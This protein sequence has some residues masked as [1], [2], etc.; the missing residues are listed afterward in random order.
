MEASRNFANKLWNAARF[1][2][3]NLGEEDF[4]PYIPQELTLEDKWVLSKYN[5]L[6]KEVTEN[7]DKFELGVAVS[8]LYDFIWDVLCDW[9]IELCKIRLSSEDPALKKNACAVLTYVMG[10]TLKLLHPFMPFITEEIWQSLP[11]EGDSIMV[12]AWP[13]YDAALDF[14]QECENMELIMAAVKAVRNR[15][16]EMNVPPSKKAQLNI[17]T[18]FTELFGGAEKYF[19]CLASASGVAASETADFDTEQSVCVITQGARIYIPMTQLIDF[20]AERKRLSKELED[21][22]KKLAQIRGKLSN[23]GFLAK[24]PEKVIA[25]QRESEA[26]FAAREQMLLESIAKLV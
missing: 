17:E 10:N 7:L 5:T 24:A 12:S 1:I 11:H 16:A 13:Q 15:R 4:A 6:V 8:K 20:E 18:E 14:P 9:Y 25:E 21:V 23:E 22:Q 3:M 19:V 26:K 2:L